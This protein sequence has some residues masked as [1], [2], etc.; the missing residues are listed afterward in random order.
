MKILVSGSTKAVARDYPGHGQRVGVLL[1]PGNWNTVASVLAAGLPWAIDNGAYSGFDEPAFRRLVAASVGQPRLL[2]VAAPDVVGDA[3]AT[4]ALFARWLPDLRSAGVPVAFVGQDGAE[5]LPLPWGDLDCFF[6]GGSTAWKLS[7]A[8]ADL[9]TEAR[10]RG[11]W[12]HM[13]RVNS[14]RRL[15]VAHDRGCDSVDGSGYSRFAAVARLKGR[16]DMLLERHLRYLAELD[17]S[18]TLFA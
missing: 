16:S 7:Q 3:S 11:K 17:A 12:V 6:V 14:L 1:T 10:Q 9:C 4:L 18:P 5:S 2:W 15:R 13:G 8:S